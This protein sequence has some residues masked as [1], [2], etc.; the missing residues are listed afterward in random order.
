MQTTTT[1]PRPETA[2][3]LTAESLLRLAAREIAAIH[4]PG[5]YPADFARQ[6]AE[7]TLRHRALGSYHKELSSSVGRVHMPHVDTAFD[8][9]LIRQYNDGA[10]PAIHDIRS[11]FLPQLSPIDHLRLLLQ[12]LWPAGANLLRLRDRAC[13]VGALRVFQ[14][15]VS[16]L[17]PHNDRLEQETDAPEAAGLVEQLTANVYL[18]VPDD[19]GELLLWLREPTAEESKVILDVEGLSPDTVEPPALRFHPRPGD[20]IVFS[21]A[22]LHAVTSSPTGHRVGMAA[23]IGSTGPDRPLVYWS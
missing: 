14:P 15:G 19:G 11:M 22:M 6:A 8:P 16:Q 13:F 12:E 20:L 17:L 4:V 1:R 3:A 2:T 7:R 9:E 10:V 23:F 21:S 5:F 18:E